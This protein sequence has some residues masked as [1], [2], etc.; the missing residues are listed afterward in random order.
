M[1]Y[2]LEPVYRRYVKGYGLLSFARKYGKKFE[3]NMAKN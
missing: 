2:L 1:R 3:I